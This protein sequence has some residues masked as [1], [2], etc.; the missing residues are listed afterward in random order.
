MGHTL[1]DDLFKLY[2]Y[3]YLGVVYGHFRDPDEWLSL[4][5]AIC[6]SGTEVSY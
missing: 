2:F 6:L 4:K 1:I 3:G 5:N